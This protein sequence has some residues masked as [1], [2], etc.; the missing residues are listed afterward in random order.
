MNPV[1][2][3]IIPAYNTAPYVRDALA[4][5]Q[6]QTLQTFEAILVD[7]ASTDDTLA[8]VNA[9]RDLLG[10][11]LVVLQNERNS[12][13]SASR[14]RAL[15][16]ARGTWIA[17]LDSDDWYAP[18]RLERLVEVGE[19][20]RA[21]LVA[22][23]QVC[24]FGDGVETEEALLPDDLQPSHS[25]VPVRT[26]DAI[27][28]LNL[29]VR[30][31]QLNLGY[32]KLLIRRE[33]LN[34]HRIRWDEEL[35]FHE[36]TRFLLECLIAGASFF[37]IRRP[38]YYY[39]TRPGSLSSSH[40]PE[41]TGLWLATLERLACLEAVRAQPE[42]EEPFRTSVRTVRKR[43]ATARIVDALRRKDYKSAVRVWMD[44]PASIT[45]V[46]Q[47]LLHAVRHRVTGAE[48]LPD[49]RG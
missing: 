46:V 20:H 6:H 48:N 35:R 17:L 8:V 24:V 14:N 10:P 38:Y 16:H 26:I 47:R 36:D 32:A 12:G 27:Q 33:F 9:L 30:R 40:G 7:D 21:D 44:D 18:E 5:L 3:V 22:D 15:S 34:A 28:N 25:V 2:S 41:H 19:R 37:L 42:L 11:R 31:R 4:S 43:Y 39:R 1:V 49:R 45:A 23:N 13:V 29:R